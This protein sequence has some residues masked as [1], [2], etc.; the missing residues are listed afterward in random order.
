MLIMFKETEENGFWL[1]YLLDS[2]YSDQVVSAA[3]KIRLSW[4]ILE[5][6]CTGKSF[7]W[8]I[9]KY[10]DIARLVLV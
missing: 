3:V 5:F 2:K 8:D 1:K 4:I 6:Q 9:L 10:C 7:M